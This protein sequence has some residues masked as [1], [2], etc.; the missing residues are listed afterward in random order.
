MYIR[1]QL[2]SCSI[3][4][5]VL[6]VF[7]C[8]S[9]TAVA[10][11]GYRNVLG[12]SRSSINIKG[13]DDITLVSTTYDYY[14]YPVIHSPAMPRGEAAFL[15]RAGSVGVLVGETDTSGSADASIKSQGAQVTLAEK[16]KPWLLQWRYQKH[17]G[18]ASE[19]T[20]TD[21]EAEFTDYK[22]GFFLSDGVMISYLQGKSDVE[23]STVPGKTEGTRNE[24]ALKWVT[25]RS[26]QRATNFELSLTDA[27]EKDS[28]G[29]NDS[30]V[31][32]VSGDY[33][34]TPDTSLGA[35]YSQQTGDDKMYEGTRTEI[36]GGHY[37]MPQLFV[38]AILGRFQASHSSGE[39]EESRNL[40]VSYRF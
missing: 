17:K 12:H 2:K 30:R 7:M 25:L 38:G 35:A 28:A 24:Y 32:L 4:S 31:I 40:F 9:V 18:T 27:R 26:G 16:N 13:G 36:R 39:D 14:I 34:F 15:Q 22:I 6:A 37:V 3:C 11:E 29:S 8:M 19:L 5:L 10:A 33:Y 23:L 20:N 21:I 1:S